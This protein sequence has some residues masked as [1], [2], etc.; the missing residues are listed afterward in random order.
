[1]KAL[2]ND[3]EFSNTLSIFEILKETKGLIHEI[4]KD[5]K[6]FDV[7]TAKQLSMI[8]KYIG[9]FEE[10]LN[11]D[12]ASL[13]VNIFTTHTKE[14][15]LLINDEM[16]N[17][18]NENFS[19]NIQNENGLKSVIRDLSDFFINNNETFPMYKQIA[20][21]EST[22][23]KQKSRLDSAI[24]QFYIESNKVIEDF[25]KK[26]NY[27]DRELEQSSESLK[28][29][30]LLMTQE[31]KND[32]EKL[33]D[34]AQKIVHIISGTGLAGAYQKVANN[35]RTISFIWQVVTIMLIGFL[36]HMGYRVSEI[37]FTQ[38]SLWIQFIPKVLVISVIG[39]SVKYSSNQTSY[40]QEIERVNR[41]IQLELESLEP[42]V[43]VLGSQDANALR[44][45]L[46]DNYFVGQKEKAV[47]EKD[48]LRFDHWSKG[49]LDLY[50]TLTKNSKEK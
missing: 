44:T 16:N 31:Y 27:Y 11:K 48:N 20:N 32:L 6:H 26:S 17:Y 7:E 34:Q 15:L 5:T 36:M 39:V 29:Q 33:R 47:I 42:Y 50:R 43:S 40:Y 3:E 19:G 49:I 1:M 37:V 9:F 2:N 13:E 46:A 25:N 35:A 30:I 22:I 10:L 8:Q 4:K 14:R 21:L 38:E 18:I 45:K 24:D 41:K 23:D 12:N 28:H